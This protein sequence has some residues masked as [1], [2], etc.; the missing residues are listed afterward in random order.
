M[1]AA[2]DPS[3]EL[4]SGRAGWKFKLWT[5]CLAPVFIAGIC[6][7]FI[8][9]DRSLWMISLSLTTLVP[10]L[11]QANQKKTLIDNR[12]VT[13]FYWVLRLL[14][15]AAAGPVLFLLLEFDFQHHL[16]IIAVGLFIG[17][18]LAVLHKYGT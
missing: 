6:G 9:S 16:G 3:T 2:H 12:P 18:L 8:S 13:R 17:L 14:A 5:L 7:L 1:T 15:W 10:G 11:L 4:K